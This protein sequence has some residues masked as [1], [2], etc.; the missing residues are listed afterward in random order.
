MSRIPNNVFLPDKGGYVIW[1][2]ITEFVF[3]VL[4]V[5]HTILASSSVGIPNKPRSLWGTPVPDPKPED[6]AWSFGCLAAIFPSFS[7]SVFFLLSCSKRWALELPW[8]QICFNKIGNDCPGSFTSHSAY[9]YL[10]GCLK[11][12]EW[13]PG[14]QDLSWLSD[15]AEPNTIDL[16]GLIDSRTTL[17]R[18]SLCP[19]VCIALGSV[20]RGRAYLR[21]Q[22]PS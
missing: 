15:S 3:W 21:P 11:S 6:L 14:A 7:T 4:A 5:E 18:P 19:N 9:T 1:S 22:I 13:L 10:S 8:S 16:K 2:V 20:L 17:L 12:W